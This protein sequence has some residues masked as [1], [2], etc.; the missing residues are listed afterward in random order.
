MGCINLLDQIRTKRQ[1][2]P[3]KY[4][5]KAKSSKVKIERKDSLEGN[6]SHVKTPAPS[7]HPLHYQQSTSNKPRNLAPQA[8]AYGNDEAVP[9]LPV[10]D[11]ILSDT[12]KQSLASAE[13]VISATVR[14]G[15]FSIL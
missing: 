10:D 4:F 3:F 9:D 6:G 2:L 15:K 7:V 11:Y 12:F 1:T 14:Q 8:H 13:E 5:R